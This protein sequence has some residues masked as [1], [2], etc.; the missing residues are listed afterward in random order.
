MQK[1]RKM[2]Q[3]KTLQNSD[4]GKANNKEKKG[5]KRHKEQSEET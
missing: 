2:T 3:N 1:E 5:R 4:K